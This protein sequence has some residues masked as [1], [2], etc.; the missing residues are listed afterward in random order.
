MVFMIASGIGLIT[1]WTD[2]AIESMTD[3]TAEA[4]G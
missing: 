3:W 1:A 2:A 4:T